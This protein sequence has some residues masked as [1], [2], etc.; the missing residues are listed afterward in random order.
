VVR[1]GTDGSSSDIPVGDWAEYSTTDCVPNDPPSGGGECPGV[2]ETAS[3]GAVPGYSQGTFMTN[4]DQ[5]VTF[6]WTECLDNGSPCVYRLTSITNGGVSSNPALQVAVSPILQ[7]ADGSYVG[8]VGNGMGAFDQSG[9]I[10][11][12][13]PNYTPTDVTADG[14]VI[15]ESFDGS[16][17]STFDA[18]GNAN[19]QTVSGAVIAGTSWTGRA[20]YTAGSSVTSTAVTP[21]LYAQSYGAMAAGNQSGNGTPILQVLSPIPAGETLQKQL[22][23]SGAPLGWNY[24]S[25]EILTTVSPATIFSNYIQTFAGAGNPP[26]GTPNSNTEVELIDVP[27]PPV[28]ASGQNITFRLIAWQNYLSC[29]APV[30]VFPCPMQG[31]F[32]VQIERFDSTAGTISAATLTGHPLAGWRYWRVFSYGTNDVVIETGAVDTYYGSWLTHPANWVG[33]K[34]MRGGQLKGWEDDL[35]YILR[36]VQSIDPNAVQGT[37]PQFNM[38]KGAWNPP[39]PSKSYILNNVCQSTSCN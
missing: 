38:V 17:F 5:G 11:W 31:A 20:S 18:N 8:Y 3:G 7:R 16:T 33:Y 37:T 12:T 10:M 36:Q 23:P 19:G 4:A 14:G 15:A 26:Q 29:A 28:T 27:P 13:V 9:N 21:V 22:P 1:V 35:R 2:L 34:V 6:S 39:T 32:S 30:P 25:I 24:N